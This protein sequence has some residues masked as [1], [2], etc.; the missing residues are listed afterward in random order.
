MGV[1][2]TGLREQD[3]KEGLYLTDIS[4]DPKGRGLYRVLD[5]AHSLVLLEDCS[6]DA[7]PALSM[8]VVEVCRR[9]RLVR[10]A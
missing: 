5:A 10:P 6:S 1:L 2:R 8:G 7:A 3:V 4:E 9:M